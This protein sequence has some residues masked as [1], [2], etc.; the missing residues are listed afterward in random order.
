MVP[1]SSALTKNRSKG[2]STE[3]Q[4]VTDISPIIDSLKEALEFSNKTQLRKK[5]LEIAKITGESFRQRGDSSVSY[6]P[7]RKDLDQIL[8]SKTLERAKYYTKR[9][10][11]SLTESKTNGINDINLYRWKE[12]D[13]IITDS[14]WTFDKR[15]TSGAH[16]GWYWGNFVPQIPH[17]IFLRF[18]KKG[19][20]VLDPFA[21]SGTTLIEGLRLGR[22]TIGVDINKETIKRAASLI[23]RETNVFGTS[24][25]LKSGDSTK[26]NFEDLCKRNGASRVQLVIMHPPYHD[27]IKFSKNSKD[28]SNANSVGKFLQGFGQVVKRTYPVL[29]DGRYLVLVAGDKYQNG[30]WIPLGFYLMEE[31]IKNGYKLTGII[32]KNFEDTR[33]KREQKKLWRYRALVGGFYVFKH[34]YIFIFK[35]QS[36]KDSGADRV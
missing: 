36:K 19:D 2:E 16:L 33:A 14:L 23:K 21:G 29:Q 7:F 27:I 32:A 20:W 8:E 11:K 5:V 28:L 1:R 12:Y 35:K 4:A 10:L 18:T 9:L 6:L 22:N 30:E 3:S 13:E 15:D 17:Q 25:I 31:I 34:E 24:S 26:I